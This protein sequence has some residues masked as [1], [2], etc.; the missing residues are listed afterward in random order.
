MY[1]TVP[2]T[3][4]HRTL[5]SE[6]QEMAKVADLREQALLEVY[7]LGLRIGDVS[8]LEWK[9]FDVNGEVPIPILINTNKENVVARS[10]ISQEFK[11]I[12]DKYL[13][14]IDKNNKYL[15]QSARKGHLTTRQIDNILKGLVKRA[16][17]VNH[18]LFRW[19]TG[20]KL[21]LRTCAELGISSWSAKLMCGKSIPASDDTYVH[22]AELRNDFTK[23]S[24]TLK[25]Y[26]KTTAD[27]TDLKKSIDL[28]F[29]VLRSLVEDKLK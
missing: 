17:V 13:N 1:K 21:F 7:L 2:T 20:R 11:A 6:I 24:N 14:T 27:Q 8:A 5:I 22:D 10:F 29:Q 19:H 16:G 9:T 23:L 25:L 3:R 26:P 18:G 4:D 15:F 12:L 28:I